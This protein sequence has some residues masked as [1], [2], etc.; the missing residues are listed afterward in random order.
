MVQVSEFMTITTVL[1]NRC[2]VAAERACRCVLDSIFSIKE[3]NQESNGGNCNSE[4]N[5]P[6]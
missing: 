6:T 3:E 5:S 1:C 2:M 4:A